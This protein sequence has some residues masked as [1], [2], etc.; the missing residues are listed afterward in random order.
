V[1]QGQKMSVLDA[2]RTRVDETVERLAAKEFKIDPIAGVEFSHI[3][4][5]IG[6]MQKR[7]GLIIEQAILLAVDA[8]PNY[9]AWA[10]PDFKVSRD[11]TTLVARVNNVKLNPDWLPILEQNLAYGEKDKT[12]QIDVMAFNRDTGGLKALEI[13]RGY[14]SHDAGKKKS[15]LKDTLCVQMLLSSYGKSEGLDVTGAEAKICNYYKSPEFHDRIS[16]NKDLLNDFFG[17]E[18]LGPVEEVNHYFRDR[19]HSLLRST[20]TQT[21]D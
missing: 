18:V 10:I 20:D 17:G 4:S 6:S 8:L 13:K 1:D 16:I 21:L 19:V 5:V 9:S 3:P 7:H 12:L 15:I 2:M 11:A 14:S